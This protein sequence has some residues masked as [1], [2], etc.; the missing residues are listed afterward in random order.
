MEFDMFQLFDVYIK[1]IQ[2]ILEMAVPVWHSS[3]TKQQSSDIESI[4]KLA[5]RIILDSKYRN[6]ELACHI[7][8]TDTLQ[9]RREKICLKYARKNMKSDHS[10][11]ETVCSNVTTRQKSNIVREY[12]CNFGRYSK[13]SIPYM[14]KLLNFYSKQ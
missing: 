3:L 12:K 14:A 7:F 1:E 10:F 13:S 9:N 5:F 4:Q 8:D 11:F 6:Y 2:S